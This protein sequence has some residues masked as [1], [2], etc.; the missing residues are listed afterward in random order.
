MKNILVL[1]C[2][3]LM[4]TLNAYDINLYHAEPHL[5]K[6]LMLEMKSKF[7]IECLV[8]TGTWTGETALLASEIFEEVY[9]VEI[10]PKIFKQAKKTLAEKR[11]VHTYYGESAPFLQNLIGKFEKNTLFWL[12]AHYCGEGTGT[13]YVNGSEIKSPLKD[14]VT[15]ILDHFDPHFIILID[16]VRGYLNLPEQLRVNRD[17]ATLYELYSLA[18]NRDHPL[19]FYILGDMALIYDPSN[20]NMT[21][22]PFVEACTVSYVFNPFILHTQK[23]IDDVIESEQFLMNVERDA[24][25]DET[26]QNLCKTAFH[27]RDWSGFYPI[28]WQGLRLLGE[29]DYQGALEQFNKLY[30]NALPICHKRFDQYIEQCYQGLEAK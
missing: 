2:G 3:L 1:A 28:L 12:D 8:E 10:H 14:E 15:I 19:A 25:V 20:F 29:K 6:K 23:E 18:K 22:S 24:K 27:S 21:I 5:D 7:G 4:Q 16:D 9:T 26:L 11:N 30:A 13:I 17:Y